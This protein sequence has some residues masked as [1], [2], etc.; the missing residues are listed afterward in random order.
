MA[1]TKEPETKHA[2]KKNGAS[3]KRKLSKKDIIFYGIIAGIFLLILFA[4]TTFHPVTVVGD[5]MYPTYKNGDL[6]I[7]KKVKENEL[8]Y[9]D[10]IVFHL[11]SKKASYI[12]RIEGIPGDIVV[13]REGVLYRNGD[14]VLEGFDLADDPGYLAVET[15]LGKDQYLALGDNRNHSTDSREFGPVSLQEIRYKVIK[16]IF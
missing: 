12:K 7:T 5:S 15:I 4:K 8:S 13:I 9:G 14:A 16:K 2:K 6:L 1:E 10:V 3:E 11:E